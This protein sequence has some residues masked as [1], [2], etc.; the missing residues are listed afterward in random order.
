VIAKNMAGI[1]DWTKRI[2][3]EITDLSVGTEKPFLR[4]EQDNLMHNNFIVS[5]ANGA[6][7]NDY[8]NLAIGWNDAFYNKKGKV[9]HYEAIFPTVWSGNIYNYSDPK[10]IDPDNGNFQIQAGS[11]LIDKGRQLT[12]ATNS[13]SN[14]TTLVVED[15]YFFWSSTVSDNK[16][17]IKIGGSTVRTITAIDHATRTLTLDSPASW[18]IGDSVSLDYS[19]SA[20]DIGVYEY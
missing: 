2:A 14:S 13:G 6:W 18:A 8:P 1:D 20:P 3:G 12:Q 15:P 11:S 5:Y 10:F 17:R 9:S 16:D 7:Q 4:P 19:G